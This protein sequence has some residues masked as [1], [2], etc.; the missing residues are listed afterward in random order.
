MNNIKRE[1]LVKEAHKLLDEIEAHISD[2]IKFA[3]NRGIE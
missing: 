3:N 1:R 2:L